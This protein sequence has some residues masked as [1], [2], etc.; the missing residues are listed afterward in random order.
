MNRY[1]HRL[2]EC[3]RI[4]IE[5]GSDNQLGLKKMSTGLSH[6]LPS[7]ISSTAHLTSPQK[8][9]PSPATIPPPNPSFTPGQPTSS[10]NTRNGP[11]EKSSSKLTFSKNPPTNTSRVLLP[12]PKSFSP[13]PLSGST[14]TSTATSST[15][16]E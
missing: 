3:P 4:T 14:T 1:S 12:A 2:P 5:I 8:P 16:G 11:K 15:R 7:M 9:L 10:K 6:P 13:I